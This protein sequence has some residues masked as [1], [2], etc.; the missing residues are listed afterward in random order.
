MSKKQYSTPN[1]LL[2]EMFMSMFKIF[3]VILLVIIV[4]NNVVWVFYVSKPASTRTGDTH[5]EI[6]QSGNHDIKQEINN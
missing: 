5:V 1:F 4:L 6:T 3:S 2:S